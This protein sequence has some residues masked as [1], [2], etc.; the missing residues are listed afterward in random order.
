MSKYPS[1]EGAFV[2]PKQVTA[3]FPKTQDTETIKK[4]RRRAA[5]QTFK[6]KPL[7]PLTEYIIEN[8][9]SGKLMTE[10]YEEFRDNCPH[11]FYEVASLQDNGNR[12]TIQ[13]CKRCFIMV[14]N[15]GTNRPSGKNRLG[16]EDNE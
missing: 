12:I 13:S 16:N 14:K 10:L 4:T 9:N 6:P 5:I 3:K 8:E 7:M 1:N 11:A 2:P 15:K